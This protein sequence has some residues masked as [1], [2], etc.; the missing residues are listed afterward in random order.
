[1][2]NDVSPNHKLV[3]TLYDKCDSCIQQA[4]Y[5]AVFVNGSLFFCGHHFRKNEEKIINTAIEV[6]DDK[7]TEEIVAT[8]Q[9]H[10]TQLV[11]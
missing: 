2:V 6:Y 1:M 8:A 10:L 9:S 11:E 3:I 7:D 4:L 5:K